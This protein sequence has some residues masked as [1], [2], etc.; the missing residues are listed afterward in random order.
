[1]RGTRVWQT[2]IG[3]SGAVVKR[4]DLVA[5]DVGGEQVLVISVR[6]GFGGRGRCSRCGRR[7]AGY[8]RG[9][10][11]RRWRSLDHGPVKAFLEAE[12]PRVRCPEHGVVVAEVPWARPAA[13][14]TRAFEDT[15]AWLTAH[16]PASTVATMLR[17]VW[18]TVTGI[19]ERVVADALAG[20]DLLDGL[21]R[22]GIDEIAHRKG[23]RYLTCV[24]DHDTG[25][26]VWAR[27]GRNIETVAAFFTELGPD[28][29]AK[30]THIS[31]D[32]ADWIHTPVRQYA[33]TAVLCLDSFHVMQWVIDALDQTR[34]S[35][36]NGLRRAGHAAAAADLKGTRWALV[37]N[38]VD[39]TLTQ[40]QTV[41]AIKELNQ[42]LYTAYLIKD[43]LH[44]VFRL[45]GADGRRYLHGAISWASRS[46]L[47]AFVRLAR[48]LRRHQ[49][50]IH[51]TLDHGLT[52]AR[53]EATNTHLRALTKRANGYHSPQRLIAMAMLTRAGLCPP[54]PHQKK[55]E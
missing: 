28:R 32:G 44:D 15:V 11:R 42:P 49:D 23:H 5:D 29:A 4:V 10:G 37:K 43:Q 24:I 16:A 2:V 36:W 33:P 13:K 14:H 51:N 47:P 40:R 6:V 7:C 26:L 55:S 31:A 30:L 25:R 39:L 18:R 19:V 35:L 8:D 52:N 3:V 34:R 54:L 27:P 1:M 38:P 50:L 45:K 53:A 22:I 20:T 48:R 46:R 12:A 9:H 21:A 41:A 17:V